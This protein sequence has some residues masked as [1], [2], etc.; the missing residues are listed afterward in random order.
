MRSFFSRF[1][2]ETKMS[3]LKLIIDLFLLFTSEQCTQKSDVV[4][5]VDSSGSIARSNFKKELQFVKEVASTFKMGPEQSQIA[6]ISYS[7]RAQVDIRFGEYSNVNDFNSAVNRVKHQRQ[8]TRIDK[9]LDLAN[10]MVFTPAG[11]ARPDVAKV[12]VI[13][14]DGKQ[15]V[16]SDSKTLDV[17][18]RP[19]LEKN[20]TVFAVGVGKAIDINELLLLVGNNP[21]NLF[22][23]ENFNELAKDSLR[24]AAQTCKKIKPPPG[25][26]RLSQWNSCFII[27]R[28]LMDY[29]KCNLKLP[30]RNISAK[31]SIAFVAGS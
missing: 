2:N 19:L 9:A 13:L 25:E 8:R 27:Y 21:E 24:V 16:T 14:T 3:V 6:V 10:T 1:G 20:V 7:D 17:A 4:F 26:T 12:M 11:G 30:K 31:S 18:V 5:V 29:D 23:A 22:R 28:Q 15:T